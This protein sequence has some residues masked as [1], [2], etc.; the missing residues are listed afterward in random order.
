[1]G[2]Q[3]GGSVWVTVAS[4]RLVRWN[5]SPRRRARV[6]VSAD[7]TVEFSSEWMIS[8]GAVHTVAAQD[9]ARQLMGRASGRHSP[10]LLV[11]C[12]AFLSSD[13]TVSPLTIC[14][15]WLRL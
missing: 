3:A 11:G 1:M 10:S 7:E 8:L 6:G 5:V 12:S 15:T 13:G 4:G 9:P 2:T 14:S